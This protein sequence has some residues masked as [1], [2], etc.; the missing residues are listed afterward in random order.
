MT[1]PDDFATLATRI[2]PGASLLRRWNLAGGVSAHVDALELEL[3]DGTS[4]RV[5]VRRHGMT[6]LRRNPNIARDEHRLLTALHAAGLPVPRPCLVTDPNDPFPQPALII[7]FIDGTTGVP[8]HLA[9]LAGDLM[10]TFLV[11]LH[12]L[13]PM[14]LDL[15]FLPRLDQKIAQSLSQ[16]YVSRNTE[17]VRA[18]LNQHWSHVTVNAPV[19]L[20]GDFWPGNI[21]WN[22]HGI[23]A[24]LD[25][26]D[27]AVGDPVADLA[28]CR[29]ELTWAF[30][31]DAMRTFTE[32]YVAMTG[33]DTAS[34]A[35]WELHS[36]L[37]P[38]EQLG[39]WGLSPEDEARMRHKL[40][41][42]AGRALTM[43]GAHPGSI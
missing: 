18:T 12:R 29:L 13:D 20:H 10:A 23:A 34:L 9:T 30:G 26:E 28:K 1:E 4:H 43:L 21:I 33:A 24:V 5:V 2:I 15:D 8:P 25:W 38:L 11:W 27:A 7:D 41:A 36:T 3:P 19:L 42:Y 17:L 35:F 22:T 40:H 16:P 31:E 14:A 6:D 32:R 37:G 39:N